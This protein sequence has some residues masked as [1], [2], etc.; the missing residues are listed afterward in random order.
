MKTKFLSDI[1]KKAKSCIYYNE[2]SFI[3]IVKAFCM[4]FKPIK[5][6]RCVSDYFERFEQGIK[7]PCR[8]KKKKK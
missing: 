7:C 4:R 5:W 1:R 3:F 6:I 8:F 2:V